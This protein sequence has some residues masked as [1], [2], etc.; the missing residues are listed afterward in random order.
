[1]WPPQN[2]TRISETEAAGFLLGAL[3]AVLGGKVRTESPSDR[4]FRVRGIRVESRRQVK[5]AVLPFPS[6]PHQSVLLNLGRTLE[7]LGKI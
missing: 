7:A 4:C 2:E 6:Y 5:T 1:M 3:G